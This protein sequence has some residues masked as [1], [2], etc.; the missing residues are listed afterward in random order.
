MNDFREEN[1][2]VHSA[3]PELMWGGGI[4]W[5]IVYGDLARKLKEERKQIIFTKIALERDLSYNVRLITRHR[6]D[7]LIIIKL[8]GDVIVIGAQQSVQ[9]S[10]VF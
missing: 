4:H 10:G 8:Y 7:Y 6:V 3:R 1:D 2:K 5:A 9:H